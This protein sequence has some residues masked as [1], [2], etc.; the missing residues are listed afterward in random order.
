[1]KPR[2]V[3]PYKLN[4]FIQCAKRYYFEY[5]DSQLVPLK[6]EI[7]KKR[8]EMEMG[9]FIH[10]S[11][12]LFFKKPSQER[13]WRTMT[14]I[15]KNVWQGPRGKIGGFN[16]IEEERRYYQEAL[17]MLEWFFKN[18]NLN[19]PIFA[20]PVSPPG[21]SFDDYKKIPFA[22]GL[23][24]GGKIDRVDMTPEGGLEI[25]D[26]KTGKEKNGALQLMVYVFLAEGLFNKPVK[27]ASYLYLK[28]GNREPVI[29]DEF[30]RRQIREEILEIVDR[31]GKE[32]E[33]NPNTSKL[34]AFCDY[35]DFCP[36]KEEVKKFMVK[37]EIEGK[38]G[39]AP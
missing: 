34:C 35:I 31:I 25:I 36:A 6:K 32:V 16:S 7:K 4:L 9:S 39:K 22:E 13:N 30:L 19:P 18:E 5:L 26:Y 28:S 10:D 11:L 29:P 14:E 24:L 23:E 27:K 15:L 1:M 38:S 33:W 37:R 17:D 12:T 3:S 8:A 21:K 20:L 2:E